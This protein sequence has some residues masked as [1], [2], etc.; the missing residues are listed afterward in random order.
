MCYVWSQVMES[1]GGW[2]CSV[3]EGRTRGLFEA[4]AWPGH[5]VKAVNL[6]NS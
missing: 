3:K 5:I 1:A 4:E 6:K 2:D